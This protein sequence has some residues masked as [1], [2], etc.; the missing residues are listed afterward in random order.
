MIP[1]EDFG[2]TG[3]PLHFAHPNAYPPAVFRQFLGP[4]TADYHV[5]AMAQRPLWPGAHP[6]EMDDWQIFAGDLL[7]FL[8]ERNLRGVI[9]VGHSLGAVA[10]MMAAVQ[11]PDLFRAL[12]L[13]E[14]VFLPPAFLES[15]MKQP[16]ALEQ[17]PM[18]QV[19]RKRRS[20]WPDRK[21]AFAHFRRKQIFKRWSDAA[22]WD[23]INEG[24][25]ANGAGEVTLAFTPE[26]EARI[27]G[28]LPLTV[29]AEIPRLTQPT[30]AIRGSESDTLSAEP[31]ALWQTL[32]PDAEY[33][34]L[35]DLG[36]MAP[37]EQ[38]EI[39]AQTVLSF[40]QRLPGP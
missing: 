17:S 5:L 10:T 25:V 20:S 8:A 15:A 6:A 30:L 39:L 24:L 4:L 7:D 27:Y 13:I 36:H 14:P 1:Y 34:E 28:R 21:A 35:P 2:G 37:M 23:Y 12:V 32:Q 38:P 18:V 22:L 11:Q 31:W 16:E 3:P 40:L 29:W 33:V 26:W 19:A 9:G